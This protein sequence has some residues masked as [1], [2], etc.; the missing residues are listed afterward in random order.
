MLAR[1]CLAD[2]QESPYDINLS[3]IAYGC[4]TPSFGI[5]QLT[6]LLYIDDYIGRELGSDNGEELKIDKGKVREHLCEKGR[7]VHTEGKTMDVVL[8]TETLMVVGQV[9][10][11]AF[12]GLLEVWTWAIMTNGA[13]FRIL[14]RT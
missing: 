12:S 13:G 4:P 6:L 5:V 8:A 10:P 11:V 9:S 3:Q 2:T 1:S 14:D 7:P